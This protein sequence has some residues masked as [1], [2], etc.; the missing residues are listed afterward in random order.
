M[1]AALLLSLTLTAPRA[2]EPV[3]LAL[4]G[5]NFVRVEP[6]LAGFFSEHF[7]Q[8]L[9]FE[10]VKVTTAADI[11]TV[12]GFERQKELL[13]CAENAQS[14]IAELANALGV[15]GLVVGSIGKFGDNFQVNVKTLSSSDGRLLCAYSTN[16]KGEQGVL[17]ALDKAAV[18]FAAQLKKQFNRS[19]PLSK[20][21]GV[22]ADG[23][24]LTTP[25]LKL[26]GIDKKLGGFLEEH[27]VQQFVFHKAALAT[28]KDIATLLGQERQRQLMGC[29]DSSK[30]Q[31]DLATLMNADGVLTGQL[32]KLEGKFQVNLK[33][34][35]ATSAST[36][37]VFSSS[38]KTLEELLP[39]LN[40]GA[41]QLA[42]ELKAKVGDE[43]AL[44]TLTAERNAP[45]SPPDAGTVASGNGGKPDTGAKPAAFSDAPLVTPRPAEPVLAT[46]ATPA[47]V[48]RTDPLPKPKAKRRGRWPWAPTIGGGLLLAAGTGCFVAGNAMDFNYDDP[49]PKDALTWGGVGGMGAGALLIAIA[50]IVYAV[51]DDESEATPLPSAPPAMDAFSPPPPPPS[52]QGFLMRDGGQ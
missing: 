43:R 49:T 20:R 42:T 35:G 3:T 44:R 17:G 9:V 52:D 45:K 28:P 51:S 48:L 27:L 11:G 37:A 7:A 36:L 32:A 15:D 22:L 21:Q 6:E 14:C 50:G 23:V 29:S 46:A 40:T 5:F 38:A 8:K 34:V 19:E 18:S 33:V 41:K 24:T 10:K 12:L 1:I 4:P 39:L 25:G 47:P 13:G 2:E 31:V 26:T 30:C 16:V